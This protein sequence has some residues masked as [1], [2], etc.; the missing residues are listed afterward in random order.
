MT[1]QA[2]PDP[3]L[4]F[5]NRSPKSVTFLGKLDLPIHRW[6]RLTPSFSPRLADDIA[7]Y[8]DL[9]GSDIVLDP[10]GGVGTVSLCMKQKGI[11]SSSIEINPFLH[12]VAQVKTRDYT[13]IKSIERRFEAFSTAFESRLSRVDYRSKANSYLAPRRPRFPRSQTPSG[14]GRPA[15]SLSLSVCEN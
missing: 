6:F 11:P 5:Q 14:G 13:D 9:S 1:G 10:F 2:Q 15:T 12:F 7:D 4:N 3:Y 8:F